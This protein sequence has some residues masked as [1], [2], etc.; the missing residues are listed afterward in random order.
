V[1]GAQSA[2][3]NAAIRSPFQG[4]VLQGTVPVLGSAR[5]DNFNF[6]KVEWAPTIEPDDWR[7]VSEVKPAFVVNGLLDQWDT[8]HLED[9]RHLLRLVVVDNDF[10]EVCVVVVPNLLVA[11]RSTPT[12][13]STST[14]VARRT[15]V[16]RAAEDATPA[17]APEPT[18]TLQPILPASSATTEGDV[19]SPATWLQMLRADEWLGTFVLGFAGGLALA[20]LALAVHARRRGGNGTR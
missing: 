19:L 8:T 10:Q 12:P 1:L 14:V 3:R 6:Y 20:V 18:A 16:R 13:T 11:N 5:I 7:A 2:C 9:G 4:E 17:E 15:E